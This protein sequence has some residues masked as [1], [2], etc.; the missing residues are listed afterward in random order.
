MRVF[1]VVVSETK[2]VLAPVVALRV[3]VHADG[4]VRDLPVYVCW[5]RSKSFLKF[6]SKQLYIKS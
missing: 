3:V 1:D 5:K 4:F 6:V 2:A